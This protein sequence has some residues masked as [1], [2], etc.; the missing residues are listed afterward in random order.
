VPLGQVGNTITPSQLTIGSKSYALPPIV[1]SKNEN[2]VASASVKFDPST[3]PELKPALD[4]IPASAKDAT[5]LVNTAVKFTITA[6]GIADYFNKD[7]QEHVLVK[8]D[9]AVGDTYTITKSN[10]VT[11]TRTVTAVST[12]DD[13]PYPPLNLNIQTITVEQDSTIP[14]IKKVRYRANHKFGIVYIEVGCLKT[15]F[16]GQIR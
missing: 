5:G 7:Q 13:F 15:L 9:A 14:G 12:Q 6:D 16:L 2:G 3:I 4:A 8:F 10:G 11:D 1:F